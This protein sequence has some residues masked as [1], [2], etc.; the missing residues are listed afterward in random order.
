MTENTIDSTFASNIVGA[1]LQLVNP[2][3]VLPA[4]WIWVVVSKQ[5][6]GLP[7]TA[8]VF[9]E[10]FQALVVDLIVDSQRRRLPG[11]GS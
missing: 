8:G 6:S 5:A 3:T 1:Y 7:R 10:V 4:G 9:T 11:R 2:S